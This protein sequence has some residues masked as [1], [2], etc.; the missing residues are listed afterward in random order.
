MRGPVALFAIEPGLM[1]MTQKQMLTA[2]QLGS[3]SSDW[4]VETERGRITMRPFSDIT[5]ERYRLYQET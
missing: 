2:R 1:K 3:E 4:V 5:K